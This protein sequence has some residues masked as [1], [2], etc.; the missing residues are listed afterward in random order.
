MLIYKKV[1]IFILTKFNKA[2]SILK[3]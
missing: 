2:N 3:Q 1:K